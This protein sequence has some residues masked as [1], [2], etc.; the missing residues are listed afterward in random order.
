MVDYALFRSYGVFHW[1]AQSKSCRWLLGSEAGG[2]APVA[3]VPDPR[4]AAAACTN[5]AAMLVRVFTAPCRCNSHEHDAHD[6]CVRYGLDMRPPGL[7]PDRCAGQMGGCQDLPPARLN[8]AAGFFA[9]S[10]VH[11]HARCSSQLQSAKGRND[12]IEATS[13]VPVAPPQEATP[14]LFE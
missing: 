13:L 5:S 12:A 9:F 10:L 2:G 3:D 1:R 4:T 7:M 8:V 14:G 6:S 11:D